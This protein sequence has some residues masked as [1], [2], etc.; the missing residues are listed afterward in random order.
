[1]A[2][3]LDGSRP[4]SQLLMPAP[5]T[6]CLKGVVFCR[7]HCANLC[8]SPRTKR[9]LQE[10]RTP[11]HLAALKGQLAVVQ[12]LILAGADVNA[13][14]MHKLRPL[15]KAAIGGSAEVCKALCSAG[16]EVNAEVE[17]CYRAPHIYDKMPYPH[18]IVQ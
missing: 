15:H 12:Q 9:C 2:R 4:N 1:M 7:V 8:R 14:D 10:G 16:A 17:V 18:L 3:S 6:I 11:L 5:E 13:A